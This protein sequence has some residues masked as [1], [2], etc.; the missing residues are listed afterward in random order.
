MLFSSQQP[1]AKYFRKCCCNVMFRHICQQLTNKM[2]EDHQQIIT[3]IQ[4]GY[5]LAITDRDKQIRS[6]QHENVILQAQR[7]VSQLQR[8]E[9]IIT[10]LRAGYFNHARDLDKDKIIIIVRKHTTSVNNKYHD[11]PYYISTIKTT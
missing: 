3:E 4:G 9:G 2:E 5:Q 8:C 6:I 11:V 7:D 10:H 1:K